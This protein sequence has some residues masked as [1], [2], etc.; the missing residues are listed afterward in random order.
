MQNILTLHISYGWKENRR[1]SRLIAL[2]SMANYPF[3]KA[4]SGMKILINEC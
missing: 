2:L 4:T 3:Q 1:L